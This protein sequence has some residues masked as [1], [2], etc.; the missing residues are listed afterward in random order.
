MSKGYNEHQGRLRS[1]ASF[2]KD[3]ARRARSKCELCE[4]GGVPLT[5]FEVA[6]VT[7]PPEFAH[8]ILV[9]EHCAECLAK[10]KY[11]E[12]ERWRCLNNTIWSETPA[13]QV[14]AARILREI[15]KTEPWAT[16]LLE[17]AYLEPEVK[18]WADEG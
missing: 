4:T 16:D 15:A 6:P 3:L 10:E 9:C 11:P 13:V 12:T 1:L 2:G 18:A 8:L 5:T 7:N 14:A 17:S